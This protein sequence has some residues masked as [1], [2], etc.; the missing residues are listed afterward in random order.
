METTA[1]AAVLGISREQVARIE[2]RGKEAIARDREL[3]DA[4]DHGEAKAPAL[5]RARRARMARPAPTTGN[6]RQRLSAALREK[7]ILDV[8]ADGPKTTSEIVEA[9]AKTEVPIG[10]W[11]TRHMLR[12]LRSREIVVCNST[13][14]VTHDAPVLRWERRRVTSD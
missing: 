9:L 2:E 14:V 12:L 8:L 1:V 3:A 13:R 4:H 7:V 6:V 11:W 10:T 5:R